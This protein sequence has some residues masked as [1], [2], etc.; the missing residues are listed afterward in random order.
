MLTHSVKNHGKTERGGNFVNIRI[1]R[2]RNENILTGFDFFD[3]AVSNITDIIKS[4][5]FASF[6]IFNG[7]SDTTTK[8]RINR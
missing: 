5:Q 1:F 2:K 8:F 7:I 4:W 6:R 3:H